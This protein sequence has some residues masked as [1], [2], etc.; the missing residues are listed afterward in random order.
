MLP[1]SITAFVHSP[2]T[3]FVGGIA[4][5]FV[6]LYVGNAL[7]V[8]RFYFVRHGRTILNVKRIRQGAEGGLDE[9]GKQQAE[10]VG[11]YLQGFEIEK[12]I[13]SPYERTK[14]TA[15]IINTH[16]HVPVFYSSLLAERRSPSEII[17]KSSEDP[18]SEAV[19]DRIDLS[20]HE[21][22]YRYS[23]EENFQDLKLRVRR[24]LA[25]LARERGTALCCVTHSFILKM[26]LSYMLYG[27]KL[28]ASDYARLSFFNP[29]G[30]AGITICEYHPW[31]GMFSKDGG[32]TILSYNAILEE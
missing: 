15:T 4:L 25:L 24:C 22:D 3:F 28:H 9:A 23:D 14:E 27:E 1:A 19:M 7:R 29:A 20:Y 18:V 13:A 2:L 26:I 30:N 17:G 12:I 10:R 32:W 6:L 21:D 16:L 11:V 8:K 5:L 31:K